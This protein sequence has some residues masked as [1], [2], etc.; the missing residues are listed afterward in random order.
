MQIKHLGSGIVL[1]EDLLSQDELS[2]ID[3]T[4]IK[5]QCV[6]QGYKKINGE[7]VMEGG[8]TIPQKDLATMPMRYNSG[9][10]DLSFYQIIDDA[11]YR[12]SVEYCTLFPV[13]LESITNCVGKHFIMY[14]PGALMG[15]H[16]DSSLAY[17]SG[18]IEPISTIALGNTVTAS[19]MLNDQFEGG[20]I[21]FKAWGIEVFPKPGSALFYPS[22]YIGAHEVSEVTSGVRWI[23]LATLTHGDI[24]FITQYPEKEKYIDRY[25][26][27]M[28]LRQD[29]RKNIQELPQ[30]NLNN[31]QKKIS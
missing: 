7:D 23:F 9:I 8:Y 30:Q 20:S 25:N 1:I 5:S 21:K 22:N 16:S 6:P 28:K 31:Y 17:K 12:G 10:E 29:V 3:F 2:L 26:W 19:I 13:S 27:T 15:V 11:L 18:T 24:S 4:K 14:L